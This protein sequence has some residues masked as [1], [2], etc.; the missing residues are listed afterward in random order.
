MYTLAAS[1]PGTQQYRDAYLQMLATYE[2]VETAYAE[3]GY[4]MPRLRLDDP[5]E[6]CLILQRM[7]HELKFGR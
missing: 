4:E 5:V 2:I 1:V 6:L 3:H 7:L